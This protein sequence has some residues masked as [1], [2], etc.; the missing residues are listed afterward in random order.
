[1]MICFHLSQVSQSRQHIAY[2]LTQ[3][4]MRTRDKIMVFVVWSLV[5]SKQLHWKWSLESIRIRSACLSCYKCTAQLAIALKISYYTFGWTIPWSF[6]SL[7]VFCPL[8]IVKTS[9]SHLNTQEYAKAFFFFFMCESKYGLHPWLTH[10]VMLSYT[11][12]K[13]CRFQ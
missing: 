4:K 13:F 5:I 11:S 6:N 1:M 7:W 12:R 8:E 2:N 10:E 3:T 9:I